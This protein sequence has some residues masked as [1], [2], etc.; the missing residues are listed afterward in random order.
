MH[1]RNL[2]LSTVAVFALAAGTADAQS[3]NDYRSRQNG[4]WS[5]PGTWER[6]N[7]ATWGIAVT[8][9]SSFAGVVTIRNGHTVTVTTDAI[10]DQVV[11]AGG[12]VVNVNTSGAD[13]VVLNG[14]GIDLNVSGR[15]ET[16]H[17]L[18]SVIVSA[19]ADMRVQSGGIYEHG[20]DAGT[21]P[22]ATW[23]TGSLC[24]ING[25]GSSA[26]AIG[27][28]GQTFYDLEW[29]MTGT[30]SKTVTNLADV[31][32]DFTIVSVSGSNLDF[33]AASNRTIDIGGDFVVTHASQSVSLNE[34]SNSVTV[35]VDG[36]F[37]KDDDGTFELNGSSGTGI[38]NVKGNLTVSDGPFTENGSTSSWVRLIG[39]SD[40]T[41]YTF[42][43]TQFTNE[44]NVEI[45]KPGGRVLLGADFRVNGSATLKM[46]QGNVLTFF[47]ALTLGN[48]TSSLGTLDWTGGTVVGYFERWVGAATASNILFPVG[49]ETWHRPATISFT[50]AP[51]TGG[52]VRAG[53]LP[54]D[55]GSYGLPLNEG[56][57]AFNTACSDGWW[58]INSGNGFAG[59]IYSISLAAKGFGCITDMSVV[60]VLKRFDDISQWQLDGAYANAT[61]TLS[62]PV[63]NRT[64]LSGFSDF[65]LSGGGDTPLPIEL[66]D[67][68]ATSSK[69]Q[70]FL[71][72]MT[73][74]E[75][76]NAGFEVQRASEHDLDFSPIAS[77]RT[78]PDLTGLG[79]S[80]T[81]RAYSFVDD[82]NNGQLVPGAIYRYRI[83]DIGVDGSRTGHPERAVRI[84]GGA[85]PGP[86][87]SLL[88]IGGVSPN[89]ATDVLN[90]DVRI[91]GETPVTFD[92][93][94]ADGLVTATPM[95]VAGYGTGAHRVAIDTRE[96]RPGA[97]TL[98]VITSGSVLSTRFLIVR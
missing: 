58:R 25:V 35:N 55:P 9:P 83:V 43:V 92:V 57:N 18:A 81:G 46:A 49:S 31:A 13:L 10:V 66:V 76:N 84:E 15:L 94:S 86:T 29:N 23:L 42:D 24:R 56:A 3:T 4:A 16:T 19:G 5:A 6:Y 33:T 51:S 72:W 28:L 41:I 47:Y 91:N 36:D 88:T 80:N 40:Q 79:T 52:T 26:T 96:L 37:I 39:S 59:G 61:G 7:G 69:G 30:S 50:T 70:V 93:I 89:P 97:Y 27:G 20:R 82:G 48:G 44:I 45:N 8:A 71:D 95:R 63:A 2:L 32:N 62:D 1:L 60:G 78:H 17:D 77:Y 11:I 68:T 87:A 75:V 22:T 73:G 65:G 21:V 34:G 14:L 74:S 38:L 85:L 90:V 12:G 98:R 53:F 64:G 54:Y 67:F